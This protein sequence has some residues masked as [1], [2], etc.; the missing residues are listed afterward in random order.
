[1]LHHGAHLQVLLQDLV[2]V[3][4]GGAAAFCDALAALTVDDIVILTL[5]IGHGV[6]DGFDLFEFAF[7]DGSIFGKILQR[8]E[9]GKHVNQLIERAHFADL[10]KLI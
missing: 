1:M 2:D 6:D 10:T 4:N 9:F 3:L 7:V 5:L 8:A